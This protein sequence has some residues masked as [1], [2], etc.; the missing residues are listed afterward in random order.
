MSIR[1]S[2]PVEQA[3]PYHD[4]LFIPT[5]KQSVVPNFWLLTMYVTRKQCGPQV[6]LLLFERLTKIGSAKLQYEVQLRPRFVNIRQCIS[7]CPLGAIHIWEWGKIM[8][9]APL[10]VMAHHSYV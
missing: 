6:E 1:P 4:D 7:L 8:C 10:I 9:H 5:L 2:F 3:I